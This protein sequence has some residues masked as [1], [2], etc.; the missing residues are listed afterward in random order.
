MKKLFARKYALIAGSAVAVL[1]I[2]STAV[3]TNGFSSWNTIKNIAGGSDT[4]GTLSLSAGSS[5]GLTQSVSGLQPGDYTEMPVTITN[6][7]T[8]SLGS[9]TLGLAAS[10]STSSLVTG[11]GSLNIEVQSCTVPWTGATATVNGVTATTY[12]CSGTASYALG[13]APTA[14]TGQVTVESLLTSTPALAGANLS[15]TSPNNVNNYLVTL[16]MPTNAPSSDQGQSVSLAYTF[17]GTQQ[18]AGAIGG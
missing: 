12:S 18:P 7:G 14:S 11:S 6:N 15:S 4:A 9:I 5:N 17:T 16:S 8:V 2:G 13:V 10:P 1:A 3:A